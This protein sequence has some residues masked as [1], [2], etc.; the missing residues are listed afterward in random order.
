MGVISADGGDGGNGSSCA[1]GGGG[2]GRIAVY[3]EDMTQFTGSIQAQGGWGYEYGGAGTV[4][5]KSDAENWGVLRIDNGGDSGALTPLT[6]PYTFDEVMVRNEGALEL[7][8]ADILDTHLLT[9]AAGGFVYLQTTETVE[10]VH[11]ESGGTL[12]HLS[13]EA[14]FDLT[15]TGNLT[16]DAG[17]AIS[18]DGKGYRAST[19]P[20]AG[21]S[22]SSAG[23][24]GG[25][26]GSGARGYSGLGGETYGS[27]ATPEEFGSGGGTATYYGVSGGR[28]AG[29]LRLTVGGTLKLDGE[30]TTDGNDGM[31]S[32]SYGSGGGAGGSVYVTATMLSGAGLISA[33]GGDGGNSSYAGGGGGGGRIAVYYED[34]T[35]FTGSIQAEGGWGY[36]YGGA[37][38][39]YTKSDAENWGVLRIDNGGDCGALTP[40]TTP[41]TFDEVIVRNKGTL[42]LS[43]ADVLE[44]HLLTIAAGG[45]V[46]L[47]TTE[48]VENVHVEAGG[49]LS[50]LSEE[51]GFDLT[52]TGNLTVDAGGSITADGKGYGSVSGPGAGGNGYGTAA[53][54][55]AMGDRAGTETAAWVARR[56]DPLPCQKIWAVVVVM[57]SPTQLFSVVPAVAQSG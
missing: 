23:G 15:V 32:S 39:I 24:G 6:A 47:Q 28:G 45:F 25:Y 13:E 55:A 19:G 44:T 42:D 40:L 51:A 17:G 26:G 43:V 54:A 22:A 31:T 12:S 38:T 53:E 27:V 41:Y 21:A 29:A 5:T 2:G 34:M 3:Y 1:G 11:V 30:L 49:T 8:I 48:T 46:Y 7:S 36:E 52:V 57:K 35:Q 10:N 4:Y 9:I 56:M 14:G 50:H 20:G 18:A 37:G 16:V 33:D